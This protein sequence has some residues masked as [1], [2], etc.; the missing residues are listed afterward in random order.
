MT[1]TSSSLKELDDIDKPSASI[2][3]IFINKRKTSL[4][5]LEKFK[6]LV[7]STQIE[8][9]ISGNSLE[10]PVVEILSLKYL[11]KLNLSNNGISV[12]WPLPK[13]VEQVNLSNNFLS[14]L[15]GVLPSLA[16]LHSI[17]VSSNHITTLAPL[18]SL[19]Q[20][21]CLYAT[22]NRL[23]SLNGLQFFPVLI[24]IDVENNFITNNQK[25]FIEKNPTICAINLKNNPIIQYLLF[26]ELKQANSSFFGFSELQDS[27]F[28]RNMEKLKDIKSSKLKL[29]VK[30]PKKDDSR[31]RKRP[32]YSSRNT[33]MQEVYDQVINEDPEMEE[34]LNSSESEEKLALNEEL[35]KKPS[36]SI[37]KL[38]L[39]KITD[40]VS[41]EK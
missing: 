14:T 3:L 24:E 41:C 34:S 11:K 25:E 19:T 5:G 38:Q 21:R 26:R 20:L 15:E 17:D 2:S 32:S 18:S 12:L 31:L 16:R 8:L 33:S 39:E 27:I 40:K 1:S 30:K 37:A 10:G 13:S 23:Q 22:N 35:T 28:Y 36:L 4:S 7:K 6:N 29:F 9:D